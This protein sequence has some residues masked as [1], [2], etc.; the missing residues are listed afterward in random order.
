[1]RYVREGQSASFGVKGTA[2][3]FALLAVGSAPIDVELGML[4]V[5]HLASPTLVVQQVI[6][7]TQAATSFTLAELGAGVD[8]AV[9]W[10]QAATVD[11]QGQ[12]ALGP[13]AATLLLDS[14]L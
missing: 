14:S 12:V 10:L 1:M 9:A 7:G 8:G 3:D 13:L 11:A 5:L 2:G 4:G 6:A